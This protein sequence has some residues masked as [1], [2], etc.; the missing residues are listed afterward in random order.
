[1]RSRLTAATLSTLLLLL[2]G[3]A[4]SPSR[5]SGAAATTGVV[6]P[7][8]PSPPVMRWVATYRTAADVGAG[9]SA[10][11]RALTGAS[12]A[13]EPALIAPTAVAIGPD[14]SYYVVDQELDGVVVVNASQRRFDLFR[15]AGAASLSR[16]AGIAAAADG[17][18]FVSDVATRAVHVFDRDL[19]HVAS[20]GGGD[21]FTR[22]TNLAVSD[23]GRRLAVVDTG[24]HAVHVLDAADGSQQLVLGGE[25]RSAAEGGFNTPYAAAFDSDGYLYVSDYLNFRIQVFAPDGSFELTFGQAGDRPGD[26]NRPRGLAVDSEA[27]VVYE[28]DGA[29]QLVQM[30]D[31]EG[32]LLMWFGG[33]GHGPGTFKLPSGIAR[34]GDLLAVADTLNS[35]FQVFRFLG[36]PPTRE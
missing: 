7:P 28:V 34:R 18:L 8:P 20:F 17:R 22:P 25:G 2:P 19:R 14:G 23:D 12:V 15:G 21:R 32:R 33:P 3:C 30:F 13:D 10:W 4:S 31:L 35:R 29:F 16:P 36:A 27:G 9:V 1:M 24:A 26:L 5:E 6:F 11:K